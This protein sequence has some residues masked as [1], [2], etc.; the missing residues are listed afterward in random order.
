MGW[1]KM[2]SNTPMTTVKDGRLWMNMI[3]FCVEMKNVS[4]LTGQF[5]PEN[6]EVVTIIPKTRYWK[7]KSN[8]IPPD[9]DTGMTITM[10]DD[11]H[12]GFSTLGGIEDLYKVEPV[13]AMGAVMAD[14]Q[15]LDGR[16]VRDKVLFASRP[17][18]VTLCQDA[19]NE[20]ICW[21]LR[22]SILAI[23]RQRRLRFVQG[24]ATCTSF[25]SS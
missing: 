5:I 18:R 4:S 17:G 12:F 14:S 1:E 19:Y 9:A 10:Q 2:Q 16:Y 13:D 3:T 7:R 8:P 22:A 23:T 20:A 6:A 21:V 11:E 25:L 24:S 15:V